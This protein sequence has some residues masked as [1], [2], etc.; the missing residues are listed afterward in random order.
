MDTHD[1]RDD[2]TD[3]DAVLVHRARAK[4]ELDQIAQQAKQALA[5]AG[6]VL[7]LFFLVPNSNSSVLLY[8][9]PADADDA[10][11]RRV[12][13]IVAQIVCKTVGLD[14]TRCQEVACA[15][16]D[17]VGDR[18]QVGGTTEVQSVDANATAAVK[19]SG[20]GTDR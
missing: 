2:Q 8:G 12:A 16:T 9:S 15:S 18:Q 1:E 20:V 10:T 6:I 4:A 19:L 5:D 17:E 3:G 14:R 7:S 11:W 13:E